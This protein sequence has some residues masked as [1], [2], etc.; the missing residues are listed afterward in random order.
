MVTEAIPWEDWYCGSCKALLMRVVPAPGMQISIRCRRCGM[1][2]ERNIAYPPK[3]GVVG[4]DV[5]HLLHKIDDR[6]RLLTQEH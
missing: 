2:I 4:D 5:K 3:N 6:L 1:L